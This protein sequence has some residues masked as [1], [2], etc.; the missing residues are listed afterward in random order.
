V[1]GYKNKPIKIS[2]SNYNDSVSSFANSFIQLFS[3]SGLGQ[4]A[5]LEKISDKKEEKRSLLH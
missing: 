2:V 1:Q 3:N 4:K 5:D